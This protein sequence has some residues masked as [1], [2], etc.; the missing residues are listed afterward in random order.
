MNRFVVKYYLKQIYF[1]P[2]KQMLTIFIHLFVIGFLSGLVI[3]FLF[4]PPIPSFILLIKIYFILIAFI[5]SIAL[6]TLNS[7]PVL[8]LPFTIYRNILCNYHISNYGFLL[9]KTST[10]QMT[11]IHTF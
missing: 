3:F 2:P 5:H 7:S 9:S 6:I 1:F 4:S 11:P 10:I 8:P